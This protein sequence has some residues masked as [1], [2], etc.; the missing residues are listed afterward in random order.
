MNQQQQYPQTY[1]LRFLHYA[2]FLQVQMIGCGVVFEVELK[3]VLILKLHLY[4]G[5]S[6]PYFLYPD[7]VGLLIGCI[8][9]IH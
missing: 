3:I 5:E 7:H 2:L 8:Q 9:G 4:L 6:F 1:S